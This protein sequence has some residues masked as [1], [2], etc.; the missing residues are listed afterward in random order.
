MP[1]ETLEIKNRLTAIR[2]TVTKEGIKDGNK[3][4]TDLISYLMDLC[5][6]V[7]DIELDEEVEPSIKVPYRILEQLTSN[8]HMFFVNGP[9][10]RQWFIEQ[11]LGVGAKNE[12]A[13][14][15][16]ET[17]KEVIGIERIQR[18]YMELTA[19]LHGETLDEYL[20][21]I[22]ATQQALQQQVPQQ[23]AGQQPPHPGQQPP[24]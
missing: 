21:K 8:L 23:P 22:Q 19:Y 6:S 20:A 4:M 13:V 11:L 7:E 24:H 9:Q 12:Q 14:A 5:D 2:D 18:P 10:A 16:F 1:L 3:L 15:F 17:F